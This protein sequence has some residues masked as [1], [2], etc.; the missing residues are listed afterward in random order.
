MKLVELNLCKASISIILTNRTLI[1]TVFTQFQ[2]SRSSV[3]EHHPLKPGAVL[4]FEIILWSDQMA[5]CSY[6]LFRHT[7]VSRIFFFLFISV[8]SS[9]LDGTVLRSEN[10]RH[11]LSSAG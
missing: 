2:K 11:K 8:L 5:S 1:L 6:A 4:H 3:K 9:D 10:M 7:E